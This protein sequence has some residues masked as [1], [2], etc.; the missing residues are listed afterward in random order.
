MTITATTVITIRR[1]RR[2]NGG[3]CPGDWGHHHR[4][5]HHITSK[6][7]CGL[8]CMFHAIPPVLFLNFVSWLR[9][10]CLKWFPI[11]SVKMVQI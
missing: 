2:R 3:G 7:L 9:S 8:L 10:S 11:S 5:R 6:G 1:R 4:H